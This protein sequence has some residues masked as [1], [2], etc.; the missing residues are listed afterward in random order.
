VV[1][2]VQ[3]DVRQVVEEVVVHKAPVFEEYPAQEVM[4][5]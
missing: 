2:V 4:D 1:P 5:F 3:E